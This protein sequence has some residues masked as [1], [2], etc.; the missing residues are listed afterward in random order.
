MS[1]YE[2]TATVE[3][4][5]RR[6]NAAHSVLLT[7]HVKP[8]GDGVGSALA[9]WRALRAKGR[10]AEI[11]LMGPVESRLRDVAGDTPFHLADGRP[12]QGEYDLVVVV[13]TGAW[14]Q[15]GPIADWLRQRPDRIVGIDHHAKGDDVA[16][17]RIVDP[18][19]AATTQVLLPVRRWGV[20][21][22][23]VRKAWP[24]PCSW[25]W[26]PTPAGSDFPAPGP[27]RC[28]WPRGCCSA[29]WTSPAST[30]SSRRR[31]ARSAW[32]SRPGPSPRWSTPWTARWP[33]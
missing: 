12:P 7:T 29:A 25:V 20:R 15:L 32:P 11:Y 10:K 9:L 5:A 16:P 2:S 26:P 27:M 4:V 31:S 3:Q 19:A 21:S 6:I 1:D 23:E 30:R 13:D 18:T 22:P 24:R 17:M 14:T 33:S 8:D 28:T